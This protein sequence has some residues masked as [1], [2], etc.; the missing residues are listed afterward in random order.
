MLGFVIG[1]VCLVGLV[2]VLRSERRSWGHPSWGFGPSARSCGGGR[3]GG[4]G[5]WGGA[6][7]GRRALEHLFAG[8]DVSVEQ[9]RVIQGAMR[10][11][12]DAA[13]SARG[14][15]KSTRDD[16]A[17]SV[18]GVT[19]DAEVL[20]EAF[21]RHDRHL[22]TLRRAVVGALGKIHAVLDDV[23]RERFAR[24]VETGSFARGPWGEPTA[25]L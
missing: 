16:D 8:L 15:A 9:A 13:W 24:F 19:L 6:G 20:G 12:R 14:E 2:K 23:Q 17:K 25:W 10:E 4:G 18:R 7:W 3:F 11:V 22:E 21:A 1:T 5:G